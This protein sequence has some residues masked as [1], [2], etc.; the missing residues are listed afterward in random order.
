MSRSKDKAA[1]PAAK[2]IRC[3]VYTRKSS[4]AGLAMEFNSLDAQREA[5]EEMRTV[6][7]MTKHDDARAGIEADAMVRRWKQRLSS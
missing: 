3:A 6:Y 2:V 7:P 4:E 1:S 5:G